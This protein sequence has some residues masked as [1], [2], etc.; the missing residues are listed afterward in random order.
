MLTSAISASQFSVARPP[1]DL[2]GTCKA[3]CDTTNGRVAPEEK[4]V[5]LRSPTS[6]PQKPGL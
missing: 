6:K 5:S 3:P 2:S 1:Y 4:Q